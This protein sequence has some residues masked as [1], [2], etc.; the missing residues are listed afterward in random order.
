MLTRI[1][2]LISTLFGVGYLPIASGTWASAI[3]LPIAYGLVFVGGPWLL[4]GATIAVFIIGAWAS[5][6]HQADLGI[7]DPSSA[8]IDE[9]AGQWVAIIPVANDLY[10]YA[11]AFLLFRLFDI[12]K[13]WPIK[14]LERITGGVGIMADDIL[15]GV[16][17]GTLTWLASLLTP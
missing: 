5:H 2:V 15:A 11:V 6:Q 17:A 8:V 12:F 13:P 1:A 3:A 7:K 9:V 4:S 10:L 14:R 16:F